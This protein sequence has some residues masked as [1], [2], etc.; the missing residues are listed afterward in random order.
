MRCFRA[1][2][3]VAVAVAMPVAAAPQM[4]GRV[5]DAP[6]PAEYEM[7]VPHADTT[8]RWDA[9]EAKSAAALE[10][11]RRMRVGE[12]RPA[13]KAMGELDWQPVDGGWVSR[14]DV[15]SPGALGLR[16]RLDLSGAGPLHILVRGAQGRVES[17]HVAAGDPVAWGPWTEGATQSVEVFG[18]ERPSAQAV[19]LGAVVH[20]D[21]PLN[22]KAA[23][24]CTVDTI[25]PSGD[26]A[27]DSAIAERTKSIARITFVINGSAFACTG[28]LLNSENFPTAFFLTANHCIGSADAASSISSF[29]FFDNTACGAGPVNPN[30]R[31][32]P[33]GM[34]IVLADYATDQTLLQMNSAP[35]AG[36]TFSG[37][38]ASLLSSG[39]SVVSISHP[40]GDVSKYAIASIA[41]DVRI[42]D[43]PQNVWLTTF[44]RGII[45]AGSS[46]SGLFTRSAD[47]LKLR[48]VLSASTITNGS[49]G[50]SCTN[51]D[52]YGIYNRFDVFYPEVARYLQ[53]S[54]APVVDD[55]GNR[56][57]DATLVTL[58]NPETTITGRIDYPGD[59]DVFRIPVTTSGTLIAQAVGGLDTVGVLMNANGEGL[60]S[61]DDAQASST[62]FGITYRVDPGT[63]Y[64]AVSY[65]EASG[66]GSYTVKL[67]MAPV[68]DNYTDLWWNPSESGWGINFNHQGQTIFATL[69]T[70]DTDGSP[71][72][73]VMSDGAK[74]ADG[75]FAGAL[76]RVTGPVFNASPWTAVSATQVGT[77]R[78]SFPGTNSGLL[79]YTFN[80]VTVDKT[81]QRQQ[82]SAATTCSWSAFDR[83]YAYNFQDLWWNPSESGWGL[84]LAH[85][86]D[87]LFATLF[88]YAAGGRGA[89]FVMSNGVRKSGTASFTGTLYRT[90]GPAF[91]AS[92]W[93]GATPTAVG[94]MTL[95]FTQ[96]NRGTLQYSIDGVSVTKSIQRQVFGF[97]TT[98]C[99]R[100][101]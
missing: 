7:H 29:W 87:I 51:L 48:A 60:A 5:H 14:F 41:G 33:G 45:E 28:T 49:S 83:T 19:R 58:G 34:K 62:D 15:E 46:G 82:F 81:I 93:T 79:H 61:N 69:F 50:L 35:P 63:Y 31:Q 70:Y 99:A 92:P 90:T 56:P 89:W 52:E 9:P 40:K 12:V 77:M 96:G 74:Q 68:T 38:D 80:G 66:T 30:A 86:G 95:N 17:M 101:D 78:V 85:Q 55:Y 71:L 37:W 26:S 43:W 32:V 44:T 47:G 10:D 97:P 36:V 25:C 100:A 75:S 54:P 76:Y 20:F 21:Q 65:W 67:S 72:W 22:A 8:F 98:E 91:N 24:T 6:A 2:A 4:P 23:G 94:T 39:E 88:T 64:L 57:Q 42:P 11:P 1:L 53:A 27:L 3:F 16:I 59:I 18:L 13:P 73:L 84:N